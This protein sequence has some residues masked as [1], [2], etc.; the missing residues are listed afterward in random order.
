MLYPSC[1]CQCQ[2][3]SRYLVT[4]NIRDITVYIIALS[5]EYKLYLNYVLYWLYCY[6]CSTCYTCYTAILLYMLYCYTYYTCYTCYTAI[7]AVG[8][9]QC[10]AWPAGGKFKGH[11]VKKTHKMNVLSFLEARASLESG[12]SV[13]DS[14]SH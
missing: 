12:P 3:I 2:S 1:T 13:T 9:R 4:L 7:H 6:T 10:G 14:L 11:K 5:L 8:G